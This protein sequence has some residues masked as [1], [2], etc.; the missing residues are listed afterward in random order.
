MSLTDAANERVNAYADAR[1]NEN[2]LAW[3]HNLGVE[4]L[5]LS[6]T[7]THA[8]LHTAV[9]DCIHVYWELFAAEKVSACSVFAAIQLL[10]RYCTTCASTHKFQRVGAACLWIGMKLAYGQDMPMCARLLAFCWNGVVP[11]RFAVKWHKVV[12]AEL[13][14]LKKLDYNVLTV[15]PHDMF[16]LLLRLHCKDKADETSFFVKGVQVLITITLSAHDIVYLPSEI[17][18]A[19]ALTCGVH[20]TG[21]YLSGRWEQAFAWVQ[22]FL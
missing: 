7:S 17:A 6:I 19:V 21:R 12:Q 22:R 14:V 8:E 3:A 9:K 2:D 1:E 5:Q 15:T 16:V 10:Y 18:L 13:H 11:P 20:V 4:R